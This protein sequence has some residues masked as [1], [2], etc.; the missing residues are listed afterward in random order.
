MNPS[1]KPSRENWVPLHDLLAVQPQIMHPQIPINSLYRANPQS[2]RQAHCQ[3]GSIRAAS[4]HAPCIWRRSAGDDHRRS[5]P[6]GSH[7][8]GQTPVPPLYATQRNGQ[9]PGRSAANTW[10]PLTSSRPTAAHSS[11]GFLPTSLH[12]GSRPNRPSTRSR[13][14]K[15]PARTITAA[16]VPNGPAAAQGV[17][18]APQS[19]CTVSVS[20]PLPPRVLS[21]NAPLPP[22]SFIRKRS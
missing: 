5:R 21:T 2:P 4:R 12:G 15:P 17:P 9:S 3:A 13:G 19:P 20:T 22:I 14:Q 16:R 10:M 18:K 8:R 11:K 6:P 7:H 1:T